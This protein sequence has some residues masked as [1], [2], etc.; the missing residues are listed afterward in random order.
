VFVTKAE[1]ETMIDNDDLIEYAVVYEQYKGIPKS[2]IH[3][4]L[5][6][7]A[8][9]QDVIMRLDVQGA[10]TIRQMIPD[11][12]L[13]FIATLSEDELIS[14][15]SGRR[16]ENAEQLQIRLRT[17]RQEMSRIPEF[18]YVVPN[19]DGKLGDTVDMV[20]SIL[21]AEKHRSHPRRARLRDT[22]A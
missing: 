7:M 14:R 20:L 11:A 1:F 12:L 5:D 3:K 9:G 22:G 8:E 2:H 15:L 18:D 19:A 6:A 21:T 16:T 10:M 4:A 17:A 13:I